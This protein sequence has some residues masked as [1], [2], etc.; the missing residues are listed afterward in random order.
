MAIAYSSEPS[1]FA[2][3]PK[4]M[5][6][7]GAVPGS[8]ATFTI[9]VTPLH[10]DPSTRQYTETMYRYADANGVIEF[11]IS[12]ARQRGAAATY[13]TPLYATNAATWVRNLETYFE[14]SV[15]CFISAEEGDD[16]NGGELTDNFIWGGTDTMRMKNDAS[17]YFLSPSTAGS[18]ALTRAT[19]VEANKYLP[20]FLLF[21][22]EDDPHLSLTITIMATKGATSID[23][24]HTGVN[25]QLNTQYLAATYAEGDW[26]IKRA[27]GT[28]FDIYKAQE[29]KMVVNNSLCVK[30]K[31]QNE[32][33]VY[34]RWL[35]SLGGYSFGVFEVTGRGVAV[36]P[37]TRYREYIYGFL[38]DV[39]AQSDTETLSKDGQASLTI[40]RGQV[41]WDQFEDLEDLLT[42]IEVL[43]WYPK[44]EAG[45]PKLINSGTTAYDRWLPVQISGGSSG[46]RSKQY[47][48]FA[49]TLTMPQNFNQKR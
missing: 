28:I 38:T 24:A 23:L 13:K 45:K 5:R 37:R 27:G 9:S 11:D 6:F 7:T 36:A 4:I 16:W 3:N 25:G 47:N 10:D 33:F 22:A 34:L 49:C 44:R 32:E 15:E 20:S 41:G 21:K 48:D 8:R 39:I 43:R 26:V 30:E 35:N 42:S 18:K 31:V 14:L 19:T 46:D 2:A 40:G 17:T 1:Y 29:Y 12:P